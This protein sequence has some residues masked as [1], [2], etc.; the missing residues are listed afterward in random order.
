MNQPGRLAELLRSLSMFNI[1]RVTNTEGKKGPNENLTEVAKKEGGED[2]R[3][4]LSS[5][6]FHSLLYS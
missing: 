4:G 1:R 5:F 3:A 6:N 2:S